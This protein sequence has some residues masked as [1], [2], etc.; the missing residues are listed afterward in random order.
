MRRHRS[1]IPFVL[2]LLAVSLAS[3]LM[4]G[5]PPQRPWTP[6]GPPG[7]RNAANPGGA[8]GF[9]P[10]QQPGH[11]GQMTNIGTCSKCRQTVTWTTSPPPSC[12]H[13]GTKFSYVNNADGTRTDLKTGRTFKVNYA[14]IGLLVFVAFAVIAGWGIY[15]LVKANARPKKKK[16]RRKPVR[17]YDDDD[18]Y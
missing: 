8:Q 6:P 5:Q 18:D 1:D 7:G 11:P 3:G 2:A 17:R 13:C 4:L 14:L 9:N 12:P 15:A 10:G 16:R